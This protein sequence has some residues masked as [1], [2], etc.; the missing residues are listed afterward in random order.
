[1]ATKPTTAP[2]QKPKA[3]GFLPFKTSKNNQERPAAPAAVLVVAKALTAKLLAAKADPALKP[4]QPNH[5]KPVPIN[6]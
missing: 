2:I 6:T 5:N 4:N 1:M 3:D